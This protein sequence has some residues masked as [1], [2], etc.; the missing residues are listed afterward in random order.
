[1]NILRR[2]LARI[3]GPI[4]SLFS[5]PLRLLSNPGR[6]L[7]F[8]LPTRVAIFVAVVLVIGIGALVWLRYRDQGLAREAFAWWVW[9]MLLVVVVAIPLMVRHLVQLFLIGP[10]SPYPE[11]DEAFWAG[12]AAMEEQ[13]LD[14]DEVPIFLVIGLSEESQIDAVLGATQLQFAVRGVPKGRKPLRWYA[15]PD[16]VYLVCAQSSQLAKVVNVA[17]EAATVPTKTPTT[18][19]RQTL[20]RTLMAMDMND[21]D[22]P[23]KPPN[24]FDKPNDQASSGRN[25]SLSGTLMAD[26]VSLRQMGLAPKRAKKLSEADA[27]DI[28]EELEHVCRLLH[29]LRQPA[30]PANGVL[31]LLPYSILLNEAVDLSQIEYALMGDLETLGHGLR[32]RCPAI[33]LVTGLED[34]IGFRELVRRVGP[35]DAVH[36]RVGR[37][38]DVRAEPSRE[39]LGFIAANMR[40]RIEKYAYRQFGRPGGLTEMGNSRLYSL[41]CKVRTEIYDRLARILVGAFG[42]DSTDRGSE[43]FFFGGCY[44]AATGQR[45]D[46]QAFARGVVSGRLMEEQEFLEWNKEAR[47][48]ETFYQTLSHVGLLVDFVL[49]IV[50]AWLVFCWLS[51]SGG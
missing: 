16:A 41:V 1:M 33:V 32:L 27:R 44:L 22:R 51:P 26:D 14:P 29:Q 47:T 43:P 24:L 11:I 46:L 20:S 21:L 39:L 38:C 9:L 37:G 42:H 12:V 5:S 18:E 31:T 4:R 45:E 10:Q 8:S 49:V 19:M 3:T 34:E 50:L 25:Q 6:L 30:C 35:Q 48:E 2:L 23:E 15:T 40:S 13:G 17:P 36:R 28:Q 7:G